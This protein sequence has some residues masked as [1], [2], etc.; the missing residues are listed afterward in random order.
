[1]GSNAWAWLSLLLFAGAL[2]LL[3]LFLLGR[4]ASAR[5]T[6]FFGAIVA[7]L[8]FAG[9]LG[10][11]LWQHRDYVR[12]D[13]AIV[14]RPVSSVKSSPSAGTSSKDLFVLHEGTMVGVLDVVG[15]WC[16]ISLSDGRQGWIPTTDIEII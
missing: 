2:S 14:M 16:N 11:A 15:D 8:L 13:S 6:G 10:F 1:M 5:R 3:L 4:T 9:A 7:A 12:A